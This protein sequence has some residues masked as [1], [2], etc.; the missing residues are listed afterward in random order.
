MQ[1]FEF[2][3]VIIKKSM[4]KPDFFPVVQKNSSYIFVSD[5]VTWKQEGKGG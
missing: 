3:R 5:S 2:D 4:E 1:M